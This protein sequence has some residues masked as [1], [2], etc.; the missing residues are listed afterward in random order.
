MKKFICLILSTLFIYLQYGCDSIFDRESLDKITS[1]EVWANEDLI[2]SNLA[3]LYASTP[4]YY[5]ENDIKITQPAYMGAEAYVHGASSSWIQ[6]TLDES[7]GVW[8]FWA[9]DEIRDINTFIENVGDASLDEETRELRLAEARFL[10]AFDYFEMVKR[11]GGVPI[12]TVPQS[13]NDSDEELYVS[14]NTEKEVYDF[15]ATECD[16]IAEILPEV[17]D[18]YGRATKYAAL[19][20]KSRAMLYAA[21]IANYGAQQLNGLLGFPASEASTYW[22]ESYDASKLIVN[23]GSFA[24]YNGQ[25][26][27][28]ANYQYIFLDEKNSETIFSKVYNGKDEVGHSFDYYNFPGGFQNTWGGTTSVYF[29][30]VEAY[31]Y[32]DGRDGELDVDSLENNMISVDELFNNK[33]PRFFASVLYPGASFQDGKVY[34]HGGT[35][36]DEVLNTGTTII[37]EYNGDN[38]YA[39]CTAYDK[40]YQNSTGFPIRKL[41]NETEEQALE[42]ESNT[43]YIVFRYGEVLLNLAEAAFELGKTDEALEY[44]NEIRE[45]AGIASLKSISRDKIRHERTVELAFEG[46]RF[47]DLRRWRIAV[48]ELSK[49]MHGMYVLF[50]WNTKLYKVRIENADVVTRGFQEK[51]YYFPITTSRISNNPNLAPENPG[52]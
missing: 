30:T 2:V 35:Y 13:L 18:E 45:R 52:Y 15:I 3:D 43:D 21:S 49:E 44:I 6:G 4:F 48:D 10:R 12:I 42:E 47:W 14:R 36:V 46:H 1:D 29:E 40:N 27:K 38:W 39:R 16:E 19:T 50:D 41:V 20:L 33:D 37:G 8:E 22:Q 51:H 23:S 26:D 25:I 9:Y 11:Y 17:A 31:E 24:L 34:C 28:A 32:T 5:A 7:G